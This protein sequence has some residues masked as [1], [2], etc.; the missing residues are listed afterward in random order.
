MNRQDPQSVYESVPP[1]Y[2]DSALEFA[3]IQ[4]S[5]YGLVLVLAWI[6][7]GKYVKME[8]AC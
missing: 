4:L 3:G 2:R 1:T 8:A 5:R 6:G 7:F